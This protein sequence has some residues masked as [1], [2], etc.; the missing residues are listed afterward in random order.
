MPRLKDI[1]DEG[2]RQTLIKMFGKDRKKNQQ[3]QQFRYDDNEDEYDGMKNG[4]VVSSKIGLIKFDEWNYFERQFDLMVS[5]KEYLD[6]NCDGDYRY[7]PRGYVSLPSQGYHRLFRL[8]QDFGGRKIIAGRFGMKTGTGTSRKRSKQGRQK[9]TNAYS[10][11][12]MTEFHIS[13][14]SWGP[15]DLETGIVIL[16][17]VRQRQ[18]ELEPPLDPNNNRISMPSPSAILTLG[19][20]HGQELHNKILR[21]GGYENVGRR[22]GLA[23]D[24][25][26]GVR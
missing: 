26:K 17:I 16:G 25:K 4:D 13:D 19:G 9:D 1:N 12:S 20:V 15:F 3:Q 18:M 23:I 5:L 2:L 21:Y 6:E 11:S 24:Y 8:I 22:L 7:F 14:L 10:S